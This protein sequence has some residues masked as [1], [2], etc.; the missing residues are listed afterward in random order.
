MDRTGGFYPPDVGSIPTEG[1]NCTAI[2]GRL[3]QLVE[4]LLY[5]EKVAGSSPA[6][7]TKQRSLMRTHRATIVLLGRAGLEDLLRF[8]GAE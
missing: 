8:F 4:Q 7:P 5:T 2:V 6:A 1:T 3:A